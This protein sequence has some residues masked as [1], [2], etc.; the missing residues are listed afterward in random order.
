[1]NVDTRAK[2][3]ACP[4]RDTWPKWFYQK[5]YCSAIA[6]IFDMINHQF[7]VT[8]FSWEHEDGVLFYSKEKIKTGDELFHTYF[9]GTALV[10]LMVYGFTDKEMISPMQFTIPEIRLGKFY[11]ICN[12][13]K[14]VGNQFSNTY[15]FLIA[16]LK[17][18]KL[19]K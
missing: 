19:A 15:E 3:N 11:K 8:D 1:M 18:S 12:S 9:D 4:D 14:W 6:P 2:I 5:S 10:Y 13:K 16:V 17:S 7:G